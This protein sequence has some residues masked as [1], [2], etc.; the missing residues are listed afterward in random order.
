M[1]HRVREHRLR[2]LVQHESQNGRIYLA[3]CACGWSGSACFHNAENATNEH[4]VHAMKFTDGTEN[5]RCCFC[6]DVLP[7]RM[8]LRLYADQFDELRYLCDA[9]QELT[10]PAPTAAEH[11]SVRADLIVLERELRAC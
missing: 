4:R 1:V 9:C 7:A 2:E 5:V 10:V 8:S 3:R 6:G 11:E